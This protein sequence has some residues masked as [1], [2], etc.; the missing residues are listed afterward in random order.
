MS[1]CCKMPTLHDH[2]KADMDEEHLT[3]EDEYLRVREH[4]HGGAR[5]LEDLRTELDARTEVLRDHSVGDFHRNPDQVESLKSE[6]RR[7]KRILLGTKRY[8]SSDFQP[9]V[10][11]LQESLGTYASSIHEKLKRESVSYH[12]QGKRI[13]LGARLA[14]VTIGIFML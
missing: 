8:L 3:T 13:L 14:P 7:A 2:K 4:S 5:I 12:G 9:T 11:R 1:L 6:V 10:L